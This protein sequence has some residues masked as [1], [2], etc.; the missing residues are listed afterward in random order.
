MIVI[1]FGQAF[2][3][4]ITDAPGA[5]QADISI[6]THFTQQ[7]SQLFEN[8]RQVGHRRDTLITLDVC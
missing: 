5:K 6:S 4:S 3:A 1:L 2:A 8:T 7:N